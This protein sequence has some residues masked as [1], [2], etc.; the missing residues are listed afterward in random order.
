MRYAFTFL[1]GALLAFGT[2][3]SSSNQSTPD[4][5]AEAIERAAD[6]ASTSTAST[7]SCLKA[8]ETKYDE[9]LPLTRAA[10]ALG[11]PEA[12]I[13]SEYSRVMKNPAYQSV[14][15]S[16]P[17][18]RTRTMTVLG[19]EIE[20]PVS[21]MIEL[22]GMRAITLEEFKRTYRAATD[23][24]KAEL[25]AAIDRSK[26]EAVKTD[27]GKALAKG[28]G[29]IMMQVARAYRDVEGVGD[30]ASFNTVESKLYV[31]DRGTMFAVTADLSADADA[32]QRTAIEIAREI[33]ARCN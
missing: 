16:V 7:T 31:L 28:I 1:A 17:S 13:K 25:D 15:Y 18:D 20:A 23:A 22:G 4:T 30:A 11:A 29:G 21:N 12:E 10:A 3:C 24:D 27:E 14:Q 5:P 6:T 9:L 19:R 8:F 32:N 33:M 2:G 26:E